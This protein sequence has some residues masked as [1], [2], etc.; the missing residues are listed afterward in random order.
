M[1]YFAYGSNMSFRRLNARIS[2][3]AKLGVATLTHHELRFHKVSD[4][5]GSG[6][7]DIFE[8]N[9]PEHQVIGVIYKID[10]QE[11][12]TLDIYEG[13]GYEIKQVTVEM[14]GV[15]L[16]AFAYYAT[17]INQELKPLH[18][19]KEHVLR[20]ARENELPGHYIS[21]IEMVESI[22][23]PDKTRHMRELEIYSLD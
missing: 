9:N 8:T 19:Y 7:C 5:D 18:W 2:N 23:D 17:Q 13:I 11:K 22:E 12:G 4:K 14:N 6:K 16:S 15:V 1:I 3:I 10:P 20:G 21:K